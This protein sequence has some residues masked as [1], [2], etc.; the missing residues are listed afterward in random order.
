MAIRNSNGG[1][2][3]QE[4]TQ[5]TRTN[6][7]GIFHICLNLLFFLNT[8]CVRENYCAVKHLLHSSTA[9]NLVLHRQLNRQT[10]VLE[11]SHNHSRVVSPQLHQDQQEV[12]IA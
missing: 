8:D 5:S 12:S 7:E 3:V 11:L 6:W 1:A 10:P 2:A 4:I 9:H